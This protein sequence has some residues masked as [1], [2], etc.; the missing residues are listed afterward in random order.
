MTSQSHCSGMGGREDATMGYLCV[1]QVTYVYKGQLSRRY[2]S[3]RDEAWDAVSRRCV[4]AALTKLSPKTHTTYHI[5]SIYTATC[6]SSSQSLSFRSLAS[7]LVAAAVGHR[8]ER[9]IGWLAG[10][11]AGPG[12]AVLLDGGLPASITLINGPRQVKTS[13]SSAVVVSSI[14]STSKVTGGGWT[15]R[16]AQAADCDLPCCFAVGLDLQP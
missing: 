9:P 5:P 14:A 13:T 16:R 12:R 15:G 3:G 8:P 1:Q 2:P 10:W 11:L 6:G 4:A 7:Y